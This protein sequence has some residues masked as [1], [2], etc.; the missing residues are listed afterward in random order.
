MKNNNPKMIKNKTRHGE[1][2][3]TLLETLVAL[4]ILVMAVVG[5]LQLASKSVG[6]AIISQNR[7]T[8][9]YLAQ[10]GIEAIR[11]IRDTNFLEGS[12]WL[13][14]LNQCWGGECY[15]DIPVYYEDLSSPSAAISPCGSD[16]PL[17]KYDIANGNYYNYSAGRDTVFRRVIKI[18]RISTGVPNDEAVVNV[19]VLWNDKGKQREIELQENI[20]NWRP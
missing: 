17:M 12:S 4:T 13:D 5:P 19:K 9:F 15:I 18:T 20:F 1:E 11:N 8:A 6:S 10:E 7:I 2:G 16:C 14:G 3:F